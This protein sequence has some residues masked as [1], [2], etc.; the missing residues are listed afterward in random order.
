MS[1]GHLPHNNTDVADYQNQVLAICEQIHTVL[2][3]QHNEMFDLGGGG[4]STR[5]D[6]SD[7]LPVCRDVMLHLTE[8]NTAGAHQLRRAEPAR[9]AG[10]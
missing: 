1:A 6:P 2:A 9:G 8:S 4:S 5:S 3:A 7:A 10:V